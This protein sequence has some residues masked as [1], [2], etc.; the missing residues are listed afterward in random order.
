MIA[1]Q[2]LVTK[3]DH[4]FRSNQGSTLIKTGSGSD[5]KMRFRHNLYHLGF[6]LLLVVK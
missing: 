4:H 2:K 1:Q 5:H 6:Y 3:S